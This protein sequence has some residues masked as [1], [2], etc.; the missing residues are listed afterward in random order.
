[1]LQY[2]VGL[3]T[4]MKMDSMMV[5]ANPWSSLSM[6]LKLVPQVFCPL[7]CMGAWM[8]EGCLRCSLYLSPRVLAVSP[9]VLLITSYVVALEAVDYP[10]FLLLGVLV[11]NPTL[12]YN[13]GK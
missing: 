6:M 2:K 5:L 13:I 1:M 3:F 10:T 8:G 9:Y 11:N 12:N 4:L 7:C